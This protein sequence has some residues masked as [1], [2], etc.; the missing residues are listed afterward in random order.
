[1]ASLILTGDHPAAPWLAITL[2]RRGVQVAWAESLM[3]VPGSWWGLSHQL[4]DLLGETT[5][6]WP[7]EICAAP[8]DGLGLYRAG[9]LAR[10]RAWPGALLDLT[11]FWHELQL[12]MLQLQLPRWSRAALN[13]GLARLDRFQGDWCLELAYAPC[14]GSSAC[15]SQERSG[16]LP[17]A[18][19]AGLL[20]VFSDA[21][22]TLALAPIGPGRIGFSYLLAPEADDA[23]KARLRSVLPDVPL[24][25]ADMTWRKA[26]FCP[27]R[28][29]RRDRHLRLLMPPLG[30]QPEALLLQSIGWV[31][32]QAL[33]RWLS[34][35]LLVL[36]HLAA[37]LDSYLQKVA[38]VLASFVKTQN[39]LNICI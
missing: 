24:T 18:G 28:L 34:E 12:E 30:L 25:P 27:P 11:N 26:C 32:A 9:Q 14:S 3:P 21:G 6:V 31:A 19:P 2:L 10:I 16:V 17:L 35:E 22:E 7:L 38:S 29:E 4:F 37:D 39:F 8:L 13:P 15:R 23:F 33:A 20:E 36:D 1:M 5:P